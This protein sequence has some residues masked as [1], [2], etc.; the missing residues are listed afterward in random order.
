MPEHIA[1][2]LD[3]K[4]DLD[5]LKNVQDL[6]L[7]LYQNF[8]KQYLHQKTDVVKRNIRSSG[9]FVV[10]QE[11][12]RFI[13]KKKIAQTSCQGQQAI[14]GLYNAEGNWNPLSCM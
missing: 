1:F 3:A 5:I 8:K 14:T 10:F 12:T 13:L 7:N 9:T 6:Y 4:G 2:T 11:N